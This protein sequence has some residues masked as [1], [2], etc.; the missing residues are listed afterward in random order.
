MVE[1]TDK[2]AVGL[3]VH[4]GELHRYQLHLGKHTRRKEIGIGV[5]AAQDVALVGLDHRLQLKHIP[6]QKHLLATKGL[7]HVA[8]VDPQD[9]VDEVDDI[10]SHHGN[11]VDDD[12]FH[13][14][15]EADAVAGVLE[16]VLEPRGRIAR[17][18]GQQGMEG[19]LE[20][21]MKGA[22]PGIDGGNA[23]GCQHHV[24]LAHV[25]TH[26][27]QEGT[28]ARA[29][30]S[31]KEHRLAGEAHKGERIL[32]F[33]GG[34]VYLGTHSGREGSVGNCSS[35][36]TAACL[37]CTRGRPRVSTVDVSASRLSAGWAK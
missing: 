31:C 34:R 32:E 20:E 35:V 22:A 10:G 4:L 28:L 5:E 11:L 24:L 15:D 25:F 14:A 23:R 18:I 17:I 19:E 3:A 2:G 13:I 33:G 37:S 7:A 26:I 16:E 6:Y 30:T 27:A 8:A 29:G 1:H 36:S 9:K 12:E 21:A